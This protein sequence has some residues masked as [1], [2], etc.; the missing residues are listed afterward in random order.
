MHDTVDV[1][2]P[3]SSTTALGSAFGSREHINARAWESVP[4]WDEMRSAIGSV[5]DA[6]TETALTRQ[7]AD[8][9]KL[10][11]HT[12]INVDLLDQDLLV[13]FDGQLRASVSASLGGDLP[14]HSWH[15][16]RSARAS[17]S[18]WPRACGEA[19]G[20]AASFALTLQRRRKLGRTTTISTARFLRCFVIVAPRCLVSSEDSSHLN[21]YKTIGNTLEQH[22]DDISGTLLPPELIRAGRAEEIRWC[23][24]VILYDKEKA[25]GRGIKPTPVRW[26]DVNRRRKQVQRSMPICGKEALHAQ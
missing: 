7:R 9:S 8:V 14:D 23:E 17:C 26:V 2:T 12:R 19:L 1:L 18:R 22:D 4:A 24:S 6:P 3:E 21:K 15:R 13:A 25:S 16:P 11:Y 20:H 5:D 10:M